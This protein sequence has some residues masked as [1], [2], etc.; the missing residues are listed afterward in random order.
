MHLRKSVLA[1]ALEVAQLNS[2]IKTL[3]VNKKLRENY[4]LKVKENL[5]KSEEL[6]KKLEIG[7]FSEIKHPEIN[8]LNKRKE[9]SLKTGFSSKNSENYSLIKEINEIREKLAR[10]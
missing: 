10:L 7:Y 8:K 5:N 6:L 4:C 3:I 9:F 1:A 2:K